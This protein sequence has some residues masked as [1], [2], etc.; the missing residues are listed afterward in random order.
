MDEVFGLM[1]DD[2]LE[3]QIGISENILSLSLSGQL[4]E[5]LQK[6]FKEEK[7]QNAKIGNTQNANLNESVRKDKIY[8]LDRI[9]ENQ[10][11]NDFFDIMDKLVKYLNQTCYTGITSYE[12]H[13]AFYEP[14]S[15]YKKHLDQFNNNSSR[16]YTLIF[17]LNTDWKSSDGGE[18]CVYVNETRQLISPN[19]CKSVFFKSNQLEHEVLLNHANRMS[20]TGWFKTD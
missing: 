10:A 15:F 6:L 17:Y 3:H 13:Y 5:N 16:Q 19:N 4:T 14:G 9:H 1:I 18:L 20:I 2:Y 12:F 7:L 8:W 11:E